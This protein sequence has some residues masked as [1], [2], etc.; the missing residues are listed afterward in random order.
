[1]E[2]LFIDPFFLSN[3]EEE[4][5]LWWYDQEMKSY[6]KPGNN[7]PGLVQNVWRSNAAQVKSNWIQISKDDYNLQ[8]HQNVRKM[9]EHVESTLNLIRHE[10]IKIIAANVPIDSSP[11]QS[12]LAP[13]VPV[14]NT[15]APTVPVQNTLAPTVPVHNT[16]APGPAIRNTLAPTVPIR[17]TLAQSTGFHNTY[18]PG[19][20]IHN[21]L[22]PTN[23]HNQS[24][25]MH[26]DKNTYTMSVINEM[27]SQ[28]ISTGKARDELELGIPNTTTTFGA[29]DRTQYGKYDTSKWPRNTLTSRSNQ[30]LY[31]GDKYGPNQAKPLTID[32]DH[33]MAIFLKNQ[34]DEFEK[35]KKGCIQTNYRYEQELQD[36]ENMSPGTQLKN[37]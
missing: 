1:M 37:G 3:D 32:A 11:V 17:T 19:P 29:I 31:D 33:M 18:A 20:A 7:I 2:K 4:Y 28:N 36:K 30:T 23:R 16:L 8:W 25:P 6:K 9:V 35:F 34:R 10:I 21:T 26:M 13:T 27:E 12:T 5:Y 14:Q 15:L 24:T 22:A